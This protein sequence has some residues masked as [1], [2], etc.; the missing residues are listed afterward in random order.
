MFPFGK[1]LG[2]RKR[3]LSTSCSL[4]K[5]LLLLNWRIKKL[6]INEEK[7]KNK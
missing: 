4:A 3:Y 2:G 5:G 7:I 6:K 1:Y